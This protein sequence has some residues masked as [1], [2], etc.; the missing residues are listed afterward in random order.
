MRFGYTI[1]YV[2]DVE[3]TL[4][5]YNQAFGIEQGFLHESKQYGELKTGEVKLAFISEELAELNGVKFT[6]NHKDNIAAGFEIAFVTDNVN[7][8]Y[9]HAVE[10]GAIPIKEPSQKPW[11]QIIAY[12]KDFNGVL[13]EICSPIAS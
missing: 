11:G 1:I 13:V 9:K 8:A 5:F 10:K 3:K 4:S 12:V 2:S 6:K 7:E